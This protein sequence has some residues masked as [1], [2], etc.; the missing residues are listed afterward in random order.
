MKK[1]SFKKA[2]NLPEM[3]V[4]F[5]SSKTNKTGSWRTL[6]P[7]LNK[8]KCISCLICW[9]FC[10]DAAILLRKGK[11]VIDYKFCKGCGIC[12]EECPTKAIFWEEEEK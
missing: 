12:V 8:K 7:V 10:P 2:K 1:L 5:Y 3:V 11:P 4:S 6:K 9:K